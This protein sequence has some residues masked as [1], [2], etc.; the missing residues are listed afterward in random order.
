[1]SDSSTQLAKPSVA[2]N[3][4][5]RVLYRILAALSLCLAVIGVFLPGLPT[6]VFVLAAAWAAARSSPRLHLWLQ[7]HPVFGPLLLNWEN[8]RRVSR[9]A[10]RTA[11]LVMSL[12][13]A[14]MAWALR[15][16]WLAALLILTMAIVLTWL[17]RRPE[18]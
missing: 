1:M 14:W 17:W 11:A 2:R 15:P 4:A 13:A 3:R 8:G 10:K 16:A 12:S 18:A 5:V 6:T 9:R 7:Q